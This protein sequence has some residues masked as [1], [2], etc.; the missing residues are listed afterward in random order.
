VFR[1][2]CLWLAKVSG[3]DWGGNVTTADDVDSLLGV[4]LYSVSDA[5][6]ILSDALSSKV[7][8]V[9]L[10]RWWRGRKGDFRDYAAV[11]ESPNLKIADRDTIKFLEL[12]EL[13][14]V[15]AMRIEGAKMRDVRDAYGNARV[16][17]GT[18]PF[19]T[20]KYSVYGGGIFVK[21]AAADGGIVDLATQNRVF[22]QIVKPLLH[23]IVVYEGDSPTEIAPLGKDRSVVLAPDRSFG[24]PI[25]RDTGVPTYALYGM[26]KAGESTK[27]IAA[28]YR[29]SESGVEDAIEYE[30][31]LAKVA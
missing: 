30:S 3:N 14:T 16:E 31:R 18:F 15:A 13:M 4:G 28:W 21:N 25:N 6:R 10:R 29:V 8:K 22:E 2:I 27:R 5:S 23:D 19:A 20:Q 17:F 1:G 9:N 24:I 26:H 12:I 7:S 11:V